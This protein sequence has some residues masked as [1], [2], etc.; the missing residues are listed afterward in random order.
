MAMKGS[1]GAMYDLTY[2][3][4][5]VPKCRRIVLKGRVARRLREMCQGPA[6]RYEVE[7]DT[8]EVMADHVYLLLFL[9]A[10]PR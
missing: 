8:Q 4:V 7:I 1:P 3:I 5:S 2:R 9:L 6:E 10:P